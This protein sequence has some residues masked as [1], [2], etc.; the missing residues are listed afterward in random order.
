MENFIVIND[1]AK[2][3]KRLD[4]SWEI[5]GEIAEALDISCPLFFEY[6]KEIAAVPDSIA[7]IPFICNVLPMVWIYDAKLIVKK[8]DS[9]FYN[10]IANIKKGY[11][12]MYPEAELKGTII[13]EELVDNTFAAKQQRAVLFSGGVDSYATLLS[14]LEE[15]PHLITLIGA[16]ID[17]YDIEGS[18]RLQI[19]AAET[20]GKFALENVVITSSFRRC[21][22]EKILN[23]KIS[24]HKI[25]YWS[26]FQHGIAI[27]GQAFPYAYQNNID[28]IYIASSYSSDTPQGTYASASD[29]IIDNHLRFASGR[30]VHDGY[31]E[32][33]RQTKV[34]YIHEFSAS[35]ALPLELHVCWQ[36]RGGRNCSHCEKCYRTM[37]A[38]LLEGADPN[39]YGFVYSTRT[40]FFIKW[41]LKYVLLFDA[42]NIV[43]WQRL[44]STFGSKK[45][46]AANKE[47]N[48][49]AAIDFKKMNETPLKKI[50]LLRSI[51]KRIIRLLQS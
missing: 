31:Y 1:V 46:L 25:G 28:I 27:C 4:V 38:L 18:K 20:A 16:D 26:G 2:T 17:L 41:F 21:L 32:F 9:S 35:H 5:K 40:Q 47:L 45:E 49:I 15:K 44:Q 13:V 50:R 3:E 10:C 36:S 33:T 29:P 23:R 8:L 51:Q 34:K 43:S 24:K 11:Q 19:L 42:A 14:H 12:E 30:V 22:K 48:W 37:F 39:N 6:S 7:V